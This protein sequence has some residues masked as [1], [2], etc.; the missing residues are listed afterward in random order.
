MA[1]EKRL[2]RE[3]RPLPGH[4]SLALPLSH[5]Y[6]DLTLLFSV[7]AGW[8]RLSRFGGERSFQSEA[9]GGWP[10]VL[11][12]SQSSLPSSRGAGKIWVAGKSPQPGIRVVWVGNLHSAGWERVG[13]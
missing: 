8:L 9:G 2:G 13:G 11:W 12:G 10:E 7:R 1:L 3:V 4:G 5:L 6:Q